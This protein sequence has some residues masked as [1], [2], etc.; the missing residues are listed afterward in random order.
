MTEVVRLACPEARELFELAVRRYNAISCEPALAD[1]L[2]AGH[3]PLC[4]LIRA[5]DILA[6]AHGYTNSGERQLEDPGADE[7]AAAGI[8]EPLSADVIQRVQTDMD[9]FKSFLKINDD[10]TAHRNPLT[11][12]FGELHWVDWENRPVQVLPMF[13]QQLGITIIRHPDIPHIMETMKQRA[14]QAGA[15]AARGF[16]VLTANKVTDYGAFLMQCADLMDHADALL[17]TPEELGKALLRK[18]GEAPMPILHSPIHVQNFPTKLAEW[19]L[20]EK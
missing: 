12:F 8:K 13:L 9:E 5:A 7:W 16:A 20:Q 1:T 4:R 17:V 6:R 15:A 2:P 10:D 18:T 11:H 3:L 14:D 19:L